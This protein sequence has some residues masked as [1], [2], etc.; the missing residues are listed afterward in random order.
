MLSLPESKSGYQH[1]VPQVLTSITR[2]FQG[3]KGIHAQQEFHPDIY[4]RTPLLDGN[5]KLMQVNA[6][7]LGGKCEELQELMVTQNISIAFISETW[8]RKGQ[9]PH[10]SI[11]HAFAG[12][13][14]KVVLN[15]QP[16]GLAIMVHPF[17]INTDIDSVCEVLKVTEDP[18]RTHGPFIVLARV[19]QSINVLFVY[20]SPQKKDNDIVNLFEEYLHE[21]SQ[22]KIDVVFGDL[23]MRLGVLSKDT[24]SNARGTTLNNTLMSLEYCMLPYTNEGTP[25][26]NATNGQSIV[27]Y[28]Y[29]HKKLSCENV[30]CHVLDE[31]IGSDHV[32]TVISIPF[33]KSTNHSTIVSYKY[34]TQYLKDKNV[35][36]AY[37]RE[38]R[39]HLWYMY[40]NCI[41]VISSWTQLEHKTYDHNRPTDD[42][43]NSTIQSLVNELYKDIE[44]SILATCETVLGKSKRRKKSSENWFLDRDLRK[45][46]NK[47]RKLYNKWKKSQCAL[48][49]QRYWTQYS[50]QR[51]LVSHMVNQKRRTI[52]EQFSNRID[53]MP[54]N[55]LRKVICGMTR[56]RKGTSQCSLNTSAEC[57][58]TYKSYYENI[59][60]CQVASD[61][62]KVLLKSTIHA[63]LVDNSTK[64]STLKQNWLYGSLPSQS[65]LSIARMNL[66]KHI[67]DNT[68]R[69]VGC[70]D[71][72]MISKT[73]SIFP[74]A[75]AP[76]KSEITIE[77]ICPI[78]MDIVPL[79]SILFTLC[80]VSG[81]VPSTW[82]TAMIC[83]IHKK[84]DKSKIE[85]YR[86]IS[87]TETIRKLFERTIF[88]IFQ[89]YIEPLS[90]YQGGFREKRST[91]DQIATLQ[92]LISMSK[93]RPMNRLHFAFLDIK[94]AYDKVNRTHLWNKM[95]KSD[96]PSALVNIGQA[97]FDHTY[98]R[99]LVNQYSSTEIYNAAG[100]L[101]GSILSPMFYSFF[102][103]D[104]P[105][106]LQKGPVLLMNNKST[107]INCL[108]YADDIVLIADSHN[109]LNQ[110]LGICELH[111]ID[112]DYQFNTRKCE[113]LYDP[114]RDSSR[115]HLLKSM[116]HGTEIPMSTR[117]KYLG[118]YFNTRGIDV[119]TTITEATTKAKTTANLLTT[120][121]VNGLGYSLESNIRIYKSLVRP[122]LEYSL[123]VLPLRKKHLDELERAQNF[124]LNKIMSMSQSTSYDGKRILLGIQDMKARYYELQ[125]N[126]ALRIK[127][128]GSEYLIYE[129]YSNDHSTYHRNPSKRPRKS[130][131]YNLATNPRYN[132]YNTWLLSVNNGETKSQST[133][134]STQSLVIPTKSTDVVTVTSSSEHDVTTCKP[135]TQ[136]CVTS[137]A[138]YN[139]YTELS[140][141]NIF[142]QDKCTHL[143]TDV[144]ETYS[145][146]KARTKKYRILVPLYQ[147]VVPKTNI[148][149]ESKAL[150]KKLQDFHLI[151]QT[152]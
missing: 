108:L 64:L 134:S 149:I 56:K 133:E 14:P 54:K 60:T 46:I 28:F 110:L 115:L 142:I 140:N 16:H 50:E 8:M 101:Q 37:K 126:W 5:L 137:F 9:V 97:L 53:M 67:D 130:P 94:S 2:K 128:L 76:G 138:H 59:F 123:C 77:M 75:K 92:Y 86:P 34:R 69:T 89:C 42:K 52:F 10:S 107:A 29:I 124:C 61:A 98:S 19:L 119:E 4:C 87:L 139:R 151:N 40:E 150:C 112:N 70:C 58:S 3:T 96:I 102:I 143:E 38:F 131:F 100:L 57:M 83:P 95:R 41:R 27:D 72:D 114:K 90:K 17:F 65:D 39:K 22:Y 129:C 88:P 79:L 80:I 103:N 13:L 24:T 51:R 78:A 62:D 106:Y 136:R 121:G 66:R 132:G 109:N 6:T 147:Q 74:T 49:R 43:Y 26:Y 135:R 18:N 146:F 152:V 30:F 20:L 35:Q 105:E 81:T 91:I 99:I 104:L 55:E 44:L 117:F 48:K 116:L 118:I 47:R 120:I 45:A 82:N 68:L 122:L 15:H 125:A 25:T 36:E 111:A 145:E 23:N 31:D 141:N 73:I 93:R 12:E 113:I 63:N 1:S 11:I 33:H 148:P 144:Y 84:G 85:N 21:Y 7:G 127:N 71:E 32:P